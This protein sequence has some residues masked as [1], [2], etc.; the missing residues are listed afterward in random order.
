MLFDAVGCLALIGPGDLT[1]LAGAVS[2]LDGVRLT[3]VSGAERVNLE[4]EASGSLDLGSV[5]TIPR[6]DERLPGP[7]LFMESPAFL[8]GVWDFVLCGQRVPG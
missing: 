2:P 8:L 5:P 4:G 3:A 1:F 6:T 7:R